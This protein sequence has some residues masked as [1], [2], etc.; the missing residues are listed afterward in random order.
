MYLPI[1]LRERYGWWGVVVFAVP[2]VAGVMLFGWGVW[3]RAASAAMVDRHRVMMLWFSAITVAFHGWFFGWF[4]WAEM[5]IH[6]AWSILIGLAMLF[7]ARVCMGLGDRALVW[8]SGVVY[9]ISVAVL[10]VT[11]VSGWGVLTGEANSPR[12][13]MWE[14]AGAG[15]WVFLIP[16][17]CAGF[18]FCPYFD[19]TFH[20]TYQATG[21]GEAGWMT[22]VM[23]GFFF[24]IM[25][26]LTA[27]Y[28]VTGFSRWVVVHLVL[29][30]WLTTT[31]H[32]RE[33]VRWTRPF[34]EAAR[35]RRM[36]RVPFVLVFLAPM[37]FIDYRDWFVFYGLVFPVYGMLR[38]L[39]VWAGRR[40]SDSATI[41]LYVFGS[42]PFGIAGFLAGHEWALVLPPIVV[43]I[44]ALWGG[45]RRVLKAEDA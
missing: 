3:S 37:V 44:V 15:R 43:A 2:N 33:M 16:V 35:L 28:S 30:G 9:G 22:F 5:E 14:S 12:V 8:I 1:V 31:L 41:S 26:A 45:G 40:E 34:N 24:A 39:R 27:V 13:A 19:L 21:G 29:Q 38:G 25:L 7:F 6:P 36:L 42:V 17:M 32:M 20:R 4:W 10:V 23:F 11:V 18:L